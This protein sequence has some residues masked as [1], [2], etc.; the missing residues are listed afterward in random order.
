M[1]EGN[2]DMMIIVQHLTGSPIFIIGALAIMCFCLLL[3]THFA[4]L[5]RTGSDR[6]PVLRI[7]AWNYLPLIVLF[8]LLLMILPGVWH[9]LGSE[10][11]VGNLLVFLSVVGFSYYFI[12]ASWRVC[13]ELVELPPA[14]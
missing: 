1:K 14:E 5:D 11:W 2:N 9:L 13:S 10:N 12:Q 4:D 6:W 3:I 8:L 7:L